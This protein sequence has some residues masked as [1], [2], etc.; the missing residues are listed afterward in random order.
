MRVAVVVLVERKAPEVLAA[1]VM[2]LQTLLLEHLVRQTQAVEVVVV[3]TRK[4][5]VQAA[6]V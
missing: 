5:V 3:Q 4:L 2:A 1:A 6:A